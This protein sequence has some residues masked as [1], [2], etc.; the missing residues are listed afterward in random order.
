MTA[1]QTNYPYIPLNSRDKSLILMDVVD[2]FTPIDKETQ[3]P[4]LY[5]TMTTKNKFKIKVRKPNGEKLWTVISSVDKVK[6]RDGMTDAIN[7]VFDPTRRGVLMSPKFVYQLLPLVLDEGEQECTEC[8][9]VSTITA[10]LSITNPRNADV[11]KDVNAYLAALGDDMVIGH[12]VG[13][14]DTF[15][16]PKEIAKRLNEYH[17]F[18][19]DMEELHGPLFKCSGTEQSKNWL[20]R[21]NIMWSEDKLH[22]DVIGLGREMWGDVEGLRFYSPQT[23]GGLTLPDSVVFNLN[24]SLKID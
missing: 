14:I 19:D 8:D 11:S 5:R 2:A 6:K 18:V 24:D 23:G 16:T 9:I 7:I 21:S 3:C 15:I 4:V 20:C 12:K 1:M 22:E 13:N 10:M 17:L